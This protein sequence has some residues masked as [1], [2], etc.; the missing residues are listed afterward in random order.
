VTF[1][2]LPT[3]LLLLLATSTVL[4]AVHELPWLS[5][6]YRTDIKTAINE[7]TIVYLDAGV[8]SGLTVLVNRMFLDL[9]AHRQLFSIMNNEIIS[10]NVY[11]RLV[12]VEEVA[13]HDVIED[14]R[15]NM[16][17]VR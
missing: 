6:V 2:S 7:N 16:V 15:R 12:I 17:I 1:C 14:Q 9:L 13:N 10:F 5:K 4:K 11:Q 8:S 3:S